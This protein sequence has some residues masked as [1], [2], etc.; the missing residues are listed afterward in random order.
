VLRIALRNLCD[1]GLIRNEQRN[2]AR[3][4]GSGARSWVII[5]EIQSCMA[6]KEEAKVL[7][8]TPPP[9]PA[10]PSRWRARTRV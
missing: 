9:S 10:S 4:T 7:I 6:S 2:W 1:G 8:S 5:I 3:T